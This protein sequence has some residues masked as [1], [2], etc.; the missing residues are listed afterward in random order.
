MPKFGL[1]SA[2]GLIRCVQFSGGGVFLGAAASG[3]GGADHRRGPRVHEGGGAG[4]DGAASGEDVVDE[5]EPLP[6]HPLRMGDAVDIFHIFRPVLR[7][8]Q[9]GLAAVVPDLSDGG[10][11][12]AAPD[13]CRFVRQEPGLVESPLVVALEADGD[14]GDLVELAAQKFPGGL[15][16]IAGEDFGP[17]RGFAE[18]EGFDAVRNRLVVVEGYGGGEAVDLQEDL[19]VGAVGQGG[20]APGTDPPRRLYPTPRPPPRPRRG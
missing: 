12:A 1:I 3:Q 9:G 7:G 2:A 14:E 18:L 16:Q 10:D 8:V 4:G 5:Q 19:I 15:G 11:S 13:F 20:F 17:P 6:G